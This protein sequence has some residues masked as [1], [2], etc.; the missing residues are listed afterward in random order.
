MIEIA[1]NAEFVE[2]TVGGIHFAI[3]VFIQFGQCSKAMCGGRAVFEQ[4]IVAKEFAAVVDFAVAVAVVHQNAVIAV[5]P[6]G[7]GADAEPL[8]VEH[9]AVMIVGGEGFEAVAIQAEGEGVVLEEDTVAIN[10]M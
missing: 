3:A 6:A 10:G 5:H 4:G 9:R 8:V 1:P 7:S 2:G